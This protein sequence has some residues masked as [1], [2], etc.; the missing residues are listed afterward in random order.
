MTLREA[1]VIFTKCK[2]EL[3]LWVDARGY[4]IADGEGMD[5][6]TAKD[7][8]T[9]HMKGSLH[10]I[11]LAQDFDLYKDGVYLDK[12]EDHKPLGDQWKRIGA[13]YGIP[14]AWGGD[15]KDK[16]GKPKPDGNHYA[17]TWEGKS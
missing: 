5:R 16:D 13:K 1:R 9:D 4:E 10:E 11:G 17:L 8:T 6:I 3:V 12:S 15:F 2:A 7:P 14:L